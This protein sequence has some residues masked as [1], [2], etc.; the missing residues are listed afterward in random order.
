MIHYAGSTVYYYIMYCMLVY[1]T[2]PRTT[3]QVFQTTADLSFRKDKLKKTASKWLVANSQVVYGLAFNP[4]CSHLVVR[5][6]DKAAPVKVYDYNGTLRHQ[7][8]DTIVGACEDRRVAMDT[9]R[10]TILLPCGDSLVCVNKE[11][12]ETGCVKV[13]YYTCIL[14]QGGGCAYYLPM[15]TT[16]HNH[17]SGKPLRRDTYWILQGSYL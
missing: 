13:R 3:L 10:D 2:L 12:Q 17:G 4:H 9:R 6:S 14:L 5:T 16:Y 8:G 7:F 11:G 1:F 15:Y